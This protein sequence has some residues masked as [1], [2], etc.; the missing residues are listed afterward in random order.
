MVRTFACV[1]VIAVVAVAAA[2]FGDDDDPKPVACSTE[3]TCTNLPD[4]AA[5]VRENATC[6]PTLMATPDCPR[7]LAERCHDA[8]DHRWK[9]KLVR[10]CHTVWAIPLA[11]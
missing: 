8:R 6:R 5:I 1:L 4:I 10:K 3:V 9:G 11:Q 2:W 7:P